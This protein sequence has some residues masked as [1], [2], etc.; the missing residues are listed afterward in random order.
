MRR[1]RIWKRPVELDA[2]GSATANLQ[3]ILEHFVHHLET[4]ERG[5]PKRYAMKR[6]KTVRD[7]TQTGMAGKDPCKSCS[8]ASA[9]GVPFSKSVQ[10]KTAFRQEPFAPGTGLG[11]AFADCE[12]AS[13]TFQVQP[14]HLGGGE[15]PPAHVAAAASTSEQRGSVLDH[16]VLATLH[17][18]RC[19]LQRKLP[20]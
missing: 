4:L 1:C 15:V 14:L 10:G 11:V 16:L 18:R 13:F 2:V 19:Q 6:Q 3:A 7:H 9:C 20:G 5:G 12:S 17:V 8:C